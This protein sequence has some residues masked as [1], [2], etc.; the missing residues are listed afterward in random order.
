MIILC[1]RYEKTTE[2][3][4]RWAMK[5]YVRWMR[6]RNYQVLHGLIPFD[7]SVPDPDDLVVMEIPE[8]VKVMC[9]FINEV[10]NSAGEDYN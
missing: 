1:C 2:S 7:R 5:A 3:K 10:K 8:I 9:L 4:I 6:C